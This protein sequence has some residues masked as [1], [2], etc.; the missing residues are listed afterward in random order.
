MNEQRRTVGRESRQRGEARVRR[1]RLLGDS[2]PGCRPGRSRERHVE[3]V[4]ITPNAI[5]VGARPPTAS[6]ARERLG[7]AAAPI[8][9]SRRERRVDAAAG[10]SI[11]SDA[12]IA[13]TRGISAR[14][15]RLRLTTTTR[16]ASVDRA[17]E[18]ALTPGRAGRCVGISGRGRAR[19]RRRR[20]APAP[21]ASRRPASRSSS[22]MPAIEAALASADRVTLTGSS[23]PW[24]TRSPYSPVAALKPVPT[25]ASRTLATTT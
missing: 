11:D 12:R 1:H 22:S 14:R 8:S 20:R 4:L 6:S 21:R 3:A 7:P 18:G 24:A 23:T 13:G 16:P 17:S 5:E 2:S 15:R 25:P 19:A 9:R 10:S